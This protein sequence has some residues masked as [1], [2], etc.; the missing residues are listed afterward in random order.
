[1]DV[2]QVKMDQ[3]FPLSGP[4]PPHVP[5]KNLRGLVEGDFT[6]RVSFLPPSHQYQSNEG[7]TKH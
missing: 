6:G 7:N 1:M 5:E 3:P 2:L 4:L